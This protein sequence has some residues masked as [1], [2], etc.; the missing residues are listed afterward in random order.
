MLTIETVLSLYV[1]LRKNLLISASRLPSQSLIGYH[2]P[3]WIAFPICRKIL[4]ERPGQDVQAAKVCVSGLDDQARPAVNENACA[5]Q[6][7]SF[8]REFF[9]SE[10]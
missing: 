9:S 7:V 5:C 1:E 8:M 2:D 4:E 6:Q 3:P 10:S